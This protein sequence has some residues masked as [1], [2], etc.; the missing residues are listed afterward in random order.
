MAGVCWPPMVTCATPGIWLICWTSLVETLSST[1]VSGN[2][3]ELA[4]S[5]RIGE[6]AGLT[7]L[8]VGGVGKF[9][10]NCPPAALIASSTS[11]AA[12]SILR[13]RSNCSVIAVEPSVETEVICE[14]PEICA[15]CV[16][17]GCAT[18]EAIVSGLAPGSC[19]DTCSVGKSTC[20]SGA[21]GKFG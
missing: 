13:L 2:D 5:R 9:F 4:E 7:F 11:L 3:W 18:A 20:G 10:G 1:T 8:K 12:P 6:S 19:A 16:S 17:S 14:T 15:N 21:T